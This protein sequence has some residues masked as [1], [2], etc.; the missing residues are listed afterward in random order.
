[1]LDI[2]KDVNANVNN[3]DIL[4]T[5]EADAEAFG[6]NALAETDAFTYVN[7][8]GG[9]QITEDVVVDIDALGNTTL[10]EQENFNIEVPVDDATYFLPEDITVNFDTPDGTGLP[11]I[12]DLNW[13]GGLIGNDDL[14]GASDVPLPIDDFFAPND[15]D[16]SY[17]PGSAAATVIDSQVIITAQYTLDDPWQVDF[18]PRTIT[19]DNLTDTQDLSLSVPAGTIYLV[20]F[21]DENGDGTIDAKE[22]EFFAFEDGENAD[23]V[24]GGQPFD[25][26]TYVQDGEEIFDIGFGDWAFEALGTITITD[27]IPGEGEAFSYGESTAALDLGGNGNDNGDIG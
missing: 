24:F 4:A 25:V 19:G 3:D 7:E 8:D 10:T 14:A 26:D 20:E 13:T 18:G 2:D 16:L 27:D 5:A 1:N 9:T 17:V 12:D 22:Y 6:E 21:L 11:D 15:K 23:W